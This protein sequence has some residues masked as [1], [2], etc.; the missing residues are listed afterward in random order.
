MTESTQYLLDTVLGPRGASLHNSMWGP[1]GAPLMT[2]SIRI[3]PEPHP[4]QIVSF[5]PVAMQPSMFSINI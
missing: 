2:P 3:H 4:A 1:L 5:M